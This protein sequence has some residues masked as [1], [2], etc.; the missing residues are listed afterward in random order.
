MMRLIAAIART[1]SSMGIS[2]RNYMG[3]DQM[4]IPFFRLVPYL[5][6][7]W[8]IYMSLMILM[9]LDILITL[10]FTWFLSQIADAAMAKNIDHVRWLLL[11]GTG[12]VILNFGTSYYETVLELDA[13]NKVRR[14][15]KLSLFQH[16]LRLPSRFYSAH[17]SGDLVSRLTNDVHAVEGAIGI[18]LLNLIRMPVMAIAAFIYL[19]TIHWKLALMCLLLGPAALL[20]GGVFGKLIR[21]NG[22]SLQQY[23]GRVNSL[24]HD[25]FAGHTVMRAFSMEQKLEERYRI[26]CDQVLRMEQREAK[27]LGWL[28]A[29]SGTISLT[30]FFV[31]MGIGAYYVAQG[32]ISIGSLL[33]FVT[34][35]QHLIYPFSG[36]AK[37]WGGLQRSL[38]AIERIWKVMDERPECSKLP[39][40]I[41]PTP[42]H[43][44]I[45]LNHL[46]FSYDDKKKVL[47]DINM[48]I[49]VGSTVAFVGPSGAGKSTLFQVIMGFYYPTSGT[50]ILDDMPID[51]ADIGVWRSYMSYVP[52]ESYLFTGT[53][54][55]NIAGGLPDTTDEA[56]IQAACD[57]N[58]HEFITELPNGYD[59]W[60]GERGTTLSGGQ[61]QRITIARAILKNAPVL[62]L[63]EATA[64][65]DT[66]TEAAV[67]EALL[68]LMKGRTT[69]IIAH[70]LSTVLHADWI[71]VMDQGMLIEQGTHEQLIH[72]DGLYS[73]LYERR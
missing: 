12:I 18:N 21:D 48:M 69:L 25:V 9:M 61:K 46:T 47:R 54:R 5:R 37:Q 41:H 72:T 58:A 28:Q 10:F 67:K 57:A 8:H 17:H 20:V 56:I 55:E 6:K 19:L 3:F 15:L 68:R 71:V 63:D 52:Q 50:I 23:L 51:S 60:I 31:S 2:M 39:A 7:F 16:M 27:L 1:S 59:T 35:I 13:V 62:L 36:I 73:R 24:L 44:G 66:E 40:Y 32:S 4:R 49:P 38:A 43:S 65:L 11:L 30:S 34:L 42:L 45:R 70:R 33:A 64:S 14:Q 53:I 26:A 22:R 29:G